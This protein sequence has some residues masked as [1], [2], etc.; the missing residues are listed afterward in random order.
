MANESNSKMGRILFHELLKEYGDYSIQTLTKVSPTS[1]I[2]SDAL[3]NYMGEG[4]GTH[5]DKKLEFLKSEGIDFELLTQEAIGL[6]CIGYIEWYLQLDEHE[7]I[8]YRDTFG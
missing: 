4:P 3:S 1:E 7:R 6:A 2:F 5:Y 8:S